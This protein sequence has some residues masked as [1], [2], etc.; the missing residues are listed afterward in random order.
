MAG[1]VP[2]STAV[3]RLNICAKLNICASIFRHFAKSP[4]VISHFKTTPNMKLYDNKRIAFIIFS[5]IG[6]LV[7]GTYLLYDQRRTIEQTEIITLT[8]TA[9]IAI[10]IS[11]I[12][13]KRGNK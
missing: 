4:T 1:L 11:V 9:I 10:I 2:N 8:L 6:G 3:L 13:I 7:F 5:I 12:M